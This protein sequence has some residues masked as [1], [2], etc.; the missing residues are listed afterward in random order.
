MY[1]RVT[2]KNPNNYTMEIIYNVSNFD[3]LK[4]KLD[5]KNV[6][7]SLFI[8]VLREREKMTSANFWETGH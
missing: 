7:H 2:A 3:F 5:L 1:M 8:G 4:L 6:K